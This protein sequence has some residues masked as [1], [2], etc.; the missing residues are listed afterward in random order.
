MAAALLTPAARR[1]MRD[2][3]RAVAPTAARLERRFRALLRL[4]FDK[5]SMDALVEVTPAAASRLPS[6]T[7]FFDQLASSGSRLARLGVALPELEAALARFGDL[8]A[9]ELEGRFAPA[10]EQMQLASLLM[11]HRAYYAVREGESQAF[12]GLFRA[13]AA[14]ADPDDLLRRLL[15]VMGRTFGAESAQL[16]MPAGEEEDGSHPAPEGGRRCLFPIEAGVIELAFRAPRAW[17]PRERTLLEA[18]ARHCQ[19]AVDRARLEK[20]T[21]RLHA[22]ARE[23]EERERRRIGRELHDQAGQLLLALRLE[24]E[25]MER[26]AEPALRGR[27]RAARALAE[28]TVAEVRRAI[29]ALSPALLE[30]LGLPAALRRLAGRTGRDHNLA[31]RAAVGQLPAR[32]PAELAEAVYRVAQEALCNV[33]KHARAT[34]VNIS[35]RAADKRIRLRV[36]DNGDGFCADKAWARPMV[37]GLAGMRER[38]TLLGGKLAVRSALGKGTVVLLELPLRSAPTD[39][40]V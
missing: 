30:R 11:L 24:L 14:A 13:A 10:R 2:L 28:Q 27:L 22:G 4:R 39:T 26:Q 18:M 32:L 1:H 16:V 12:F 15:A 29:A 6:L 5:Q 7:A 34:R 8:L 21:L 31:V 25:L 38:A 9:E 37:F 33:A 36:S 40:D 35:L 20:E 19:A 3:L 23:A 17:L